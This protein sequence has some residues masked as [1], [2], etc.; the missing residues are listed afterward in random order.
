MHDDF[1]GDVA[2]ILDRDE[3]DVR[4][5]VAQVQ[6]DAEFMG[7]E[8]EGVVH[9]LEG[10]SGSLDIRLWADY[11]EGKRTDNTNLPRITPWRFGA[12]MTYFQGPWYAT[13]ELYPCE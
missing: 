8:L 3:D 6:D 7:F 1:A 5:L 11:V 9:A 4:L 2:D 10:E 13:P 12:G